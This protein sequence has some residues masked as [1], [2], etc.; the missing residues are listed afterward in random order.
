MLFSSGPGLICVL[1]TGP[2]CSVVELVARELAIFIQHTIETAFKKRISVHLN[3][4]V[5]SVLFHR[6]SPE[7]RTTL[8]EKGLIE[9]PLSLCRITL[10]LV[11]VLSVYTNPYQWN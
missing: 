6:E 7:G 8:D 10:E 11:F 5:R 4:T 2:S 9:E 1:E 3:G